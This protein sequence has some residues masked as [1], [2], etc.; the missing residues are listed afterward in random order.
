MTSLYAACAIGIPLLWLLTQ[1]TESVR[2]RQWLYL[3]ASY[4]FYL[5]VGWRF[6]AILVASSVFNFVWGGVIRRRGSA[7]VLWTGVLANVLLLATFKYLPAIAEHG[8][9]RSAFLNELAHLALPIGISFWTFQALS[10]LFDQYR[11]ENLDPTL[12]EFLLYMSFAPTVL[13]GPICRLPELLPQFRDPQRASWTDVVSGIQGIWIGV[14]MITVARYLGGGWTGEGVN[15]AF[16]HVT[17]NVSSR[18]AWLLLVAYGLQLFFDFAGYTRV[19]IG[20]AL[21]FHIRLP[22]NFRRPFFA[23]TPAAFWQ[24][25]HMSLSFWIRDYLFLP[26]ATVR[27]EVWWRN[28]MLVVSMVVFGLWHGASLLFV[29]WG[30]Y[31]GLLLLAHRLVQQWQRKTGRRM[32]GAAADALSWAVTFAAITL[33]WALFRAQTWA[34]AGT[35]LGAALT[36]FSGGAPLLPHT[37]LVLLAVVVAGYLALE[38]LTGRLRGERP[39]LAWIPIE[40]RYLGYAAIF[41]FAV[42]HTAAPQSFIYFQF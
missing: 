4:A 7:G 18:D 35:L 13:S 42:F 28:A 38:Y 29:L 24:R 2:L 8:A 27:R 15:W 6:V 11:G 9:E 36:P 26:L 10:Y 41:Y 16:A 40:L 25:W 19:V 32:T 3:I 1:R 37:F 30:T 33:A 14:L 20:L 39:L 31:Q 17:S 12:R 22:E 34:Q 23:T 5:A 21:A